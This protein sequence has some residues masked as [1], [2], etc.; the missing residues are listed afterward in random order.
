MHSRWDLGPN[1]ARGFGGVTPE[2]ILKFHIENGA[3]SCILSDAAT[4][5]RALS[6][7]AVFWKNVILIFFPDH[8]NSLTFPWLELIFSIF[9]DFSLTILKFPDISRFPAFPDKVVTLWTGWK[10]DTSASRKIHQA[11]YFSKP[12][13]I[14]QNLIIFH[15]RRQLRGPNWS[16]E[17]AY[18]SR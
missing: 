7:C 2:K 18:K 13:S 10:W 14:K 6:C 9:P 17:N 12:I 5:A 4:A 16:Y 3:L 1:S 15:I 11:K 8:I